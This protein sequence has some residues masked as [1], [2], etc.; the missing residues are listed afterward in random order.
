[1]KLL[2]KPFPFRLHQPPTSSDN[3]TT[4]LMTH[5]I[6]I[7]LSDSYPVLLE[8]AKHAAAFPADIYIV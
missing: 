8:H 2:H 6:V 3:S 4:T 7:C 1:V 5:I